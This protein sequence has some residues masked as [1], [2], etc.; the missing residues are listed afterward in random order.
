[1]KQTDDVFF[2]TLIDFLIQIFFFGLLLYVFSQASQMSKEKLEQEEARHYE[3]QMKAAGFTN[4]TQLMDYLTKLTPATELK[5]VADFFSQAGGYGKVKEAV[6]VVQ[7]AGGVDKV[8]PA[9]A[10]IK[11]AGGPEK[12]KE[13]VELLRKAGLGK[14]SCNNENG[15][16][17]AMATVLAGDSSIRFE[18]IT[19]ELEIALQLIGRNFDEVKELSLAEFRK[20][21]EPLAAKQPDCR[22]TLRFLEATRFVDARDA[23]RFIFYLNIARK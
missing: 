1:M 23:A 15:R 16:P 5:G 6:A 17:K 11:N 9:V 13:G 21:F 14:P 20:T 12:V 19:P 10:L 4:L 3:Q 7:K 18:E 22:Y 8:A 2:F